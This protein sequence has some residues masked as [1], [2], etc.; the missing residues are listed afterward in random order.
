MPDKDIIFSDKATSKIRTLGPKA[1]NALGTIMDG[2]S[3]KII[4]FVNIK[5][6]QDSPK[7]FAYRF[8][9][10]RLI[11]SLEADKIIVLDFFEKH[12]LGSDQKRL[13]KSLLKHFHK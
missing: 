2:L 10:Y 11:Y 7:L 4:P 12:E 8:K 5:Q 6:L 13:L 9:D 3:G 1:K